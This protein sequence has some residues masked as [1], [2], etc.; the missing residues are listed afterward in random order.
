[1]DSLSR[2][3]C[4]TAIQVLQPVA[5][6]GQEKSAAFEE[7]LIKM[8]ENKMK[9]PLS[10]A[11][12]GTDGDLKP[13]PPWRTDDVKSWIWLQKAI[14]P[15]LNYDRCFRKKWSLH[16]PRKLIPFKEMSLK[17]W[18]CE[19]KRK[20]KDEERLQ[21]AEVHAAISVAGVAAA[22]AAMAA[23]NMKAEQQASCTKEAALASAAALVAAQ[24]AQAAE[25][26][27]ADRKE[28]SKAVSSA[29][30]AR[31]TCDILT[32]T[33]AA[34][35]SLRGAAA[36]RARPGRK[37]KDGSGP[38]TLPFESREFDFDFGKYRNVLA[39][40]AELAV[41]LPSDGVVTNIREDTMEDSEDADAPPSI[42]LTTTSA[43]AIKVE[44][45]D[46][47]QFKIWFVTINHMLMLST[48]FSG[49]ELH[50]YRN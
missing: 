37:E 2:A 43:T 13:T 50:F 21:K 9:M 47:T 41:R 44:M 22:L 46:L 32:L 18:V 25:D 35:T 28:L 23:Q 24:C 11:N 15:E 8:F 42:V 45:R 7:S 19:M 27:G 6:A 1:M 31:N 29:M 38:T 12:G 10:M 5:V 36:L 49:Y 17:K 39:A 3:W 26:M 30:A 34:A 14:H 48:T 20:R 16:F 40:G 4:D 33:A